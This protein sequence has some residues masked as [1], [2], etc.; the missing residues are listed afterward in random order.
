MARHLSIKC[1]LFGQRA[2]SLHVSS[3]EQYITRGERCQH[4]VSV[5]RNS[6]CGASIDIV[7]L[8]GWQRHGVYI[9]MLRPEAVSKTLANPEACISLWRMAT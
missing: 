7:Q 3:L 6:M 4:G 9:S 1:S 2:C 8:V 5:V